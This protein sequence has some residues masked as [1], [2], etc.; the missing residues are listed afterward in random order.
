MRPTTDTARP[1][2]GEEKPANSS[3]RRL[4][5][6]DAATVTD[7]N[8][9][10]SGSITE[11][12]A[13]TSVTVAQDAAS[14]QPENGLIYAWPLTDIWGAAIDHTAPFACRLLLSIVTA[15]G[16]TSDLYV[17]AGLCSSQDLTDVY[18][19]GGLVWDAAGGPL[20][21][22]TNAAAITDADQQAATVNAV[23]D[24]TVG[25]S[26]FQDVR[27]YGLTSAR[28]YT[29]TTSRAGSNALSAAPSIFV[30]FGRKTNEAGAATVVFKAFLETAL[31]GLNYTGA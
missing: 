21:R 27:V 16:D 22:A 25:P 6:A 23:M 12:A 4:L 15:P 2:T 17:V 24:F 10:L 20:M 7:T 18:L 26:R 1:Y 29:A 8:N 31:V 3:W 9:I 5:L 30:A 11:S 13:S 28:A 14:N 19:S